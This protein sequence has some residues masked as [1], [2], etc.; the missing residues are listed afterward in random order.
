MNHSETRRKLESRER[1]GREGRER[2]GV[3]FWDT[4]VDTETERDET[5]G[6]GR[7]RRSERE[8]EKGGG[9]Q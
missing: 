5:R 3:S 9:E 2:K 1:G 7:E 4:K 8:R 6:K